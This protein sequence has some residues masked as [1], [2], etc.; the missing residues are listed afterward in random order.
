[1]FQSEGL[2]SII[3]GGIEKVFNA[4]RSSIRGIVFSILACIFLF[5]IGYLFGMH[6]MVVAAAVKKEAIPEAPK[7]CWW[8]G[9]WWNN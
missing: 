5:G 6:H 2:G 8:K 7:S 1:M 3:M 9:G 4:I